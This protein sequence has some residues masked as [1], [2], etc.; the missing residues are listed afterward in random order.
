MHQLRSEFVVS[1][2][3]AARILNL[4]LIPSRIM[5]PYPEDFGRAAGHA[6]AGHAP[7][8]QVPSE[9]TSGTN[10]QGMAATEEGSAAALESL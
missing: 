5:T 3:E 6:P 10:P 2:M 1:L 8:G 9:P 7:A 4:K